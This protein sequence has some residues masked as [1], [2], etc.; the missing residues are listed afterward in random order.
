MIWDTN[1]FQ[2]TNFYL[3]TNV[4]NITNKFYCQYKLYPEDPNSHKTT[5]ISGV[6]LPVRLIMGVKRVEDSSNFK[7]V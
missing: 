3:L 6:E 5:L 1:Y 4:E 7:L 2:A